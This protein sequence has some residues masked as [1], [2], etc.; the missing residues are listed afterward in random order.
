MKTGKR[1][2]GDDAMKCRSK[3]KG[4]ENEEKKMNAGRR[5]KYKRKL[6]TREER[7]EMEKKK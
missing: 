4:T 5:L 3:K 7:E 1:R 2:N 6:M